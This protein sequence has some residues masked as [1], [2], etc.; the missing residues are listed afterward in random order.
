MSKYVTGAISHELETLVLS[1]GPT[2]ITQIWI[3]RKFEKFKIKEKAKS[4]LC[5]SDKFLISNTFNVE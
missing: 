5:N 1:L 2:Q 3:K 4:F